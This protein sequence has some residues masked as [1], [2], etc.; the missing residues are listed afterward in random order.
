MK[1]SFSN[2]L[3]YDYGEKFTLTAVPV[4]FE[5]SWPVLNFKQR[6]KDRLSNNMPDLKTNRLDF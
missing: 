6:N 3:F 2:T 4:A 1:Y 5:S